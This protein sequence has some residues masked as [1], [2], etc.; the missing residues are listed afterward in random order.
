[1]NTDTFSAMDADLTVGNIKSGTTIFGVTGTYAIFQS[2][3]INGY[4]VYQAAS[5][6]KCFLHNSGLQRC[7]CL[8]RLRLLERWPHVLLLCRS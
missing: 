7:R 5:A 3:K 6:A 4:P 8:G 1:M 2:P